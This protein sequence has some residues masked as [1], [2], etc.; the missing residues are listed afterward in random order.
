MKNPIDDEILIC[1][2]CGGECYIAENDIGEILYSDFSM[3]V[4]ESE[5]GFIIRGSKICQSCEGEKE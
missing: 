5:R 1:P 2:V 3:G 4:P